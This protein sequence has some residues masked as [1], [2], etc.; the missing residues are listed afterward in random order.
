MT[1]VETFFRRT[2]DRLSLSSYQSLAFL[3]HALNNVGLGQR[4]FGGPLR[5]LKRDPPLRNRPNQLRLDEASIPTY[6]L[7]AHA[8]LGANTRNRF[9]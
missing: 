8:R 1:M 7:P 5:K 9:D 2:L 3:R 6:I 4:P